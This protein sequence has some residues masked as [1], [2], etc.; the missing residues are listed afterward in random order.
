MPIAGRDLT[1]G[2]SCQPAFTFHSGGSGAQTGCA[3]TARAHRVSQHSQTLIGSLL[4]AVADA[5]ERSAADVL[6]AGAGIA[7]LSCA[8]ALA[9]CG[10]RVVVL[11]ALPHLGGRAANWRDAVTGNGSSCS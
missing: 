6:V 9:R 4:A 3:R 1:Q 10:L 8:A 11:E 2:L 5:D 7:G